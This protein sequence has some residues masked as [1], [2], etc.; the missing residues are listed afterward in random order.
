MYV[1]EP[2]N[3]PEDAKVP[4]IEVPYICE[5]L[6]DEV[7]LH[8]NFRLVPHLKSLPDCESWYPADRDEAVK[9]A[10]AHSSLASS[11]ICGALP[12]L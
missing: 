10:Q 2:H 3:Y 8:E 7:G 9:K 11:M 4:P 12:L 1:E 5:H 6:L